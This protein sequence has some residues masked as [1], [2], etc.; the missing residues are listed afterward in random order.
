[1]PPR[2]TS[3]KPPTG[4]SAGCRDQQD[5]VTII[6]HGDSDDDEVLKDQGGRS[7]KRSLSGHGND[8][9]KRRGRSVSVE[10]SHQ[11]QKVAYNILIACMF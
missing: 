2:K 5:D 4:R 3:Q 6:R 9:N 8:A 7:S 1:M 11:W 10:S